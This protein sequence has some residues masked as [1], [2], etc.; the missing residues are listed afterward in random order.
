MRFST[1]PSID[2][3]PGEWDGVPE[4]AVDRV[5]AGSAGDVAFGARARLGWDADA[6]YDLGHMY[7]LN[8]DNDKAVEAFNAYLELN[9]GKDAEAQK[10]V[11]A[12]VQALGGTPATAPKKTPPKKKAPPK[13]K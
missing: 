1:P 13:K 11:E 7:K 12:E 6:W 4:V 3:D 10:N 5:I 9:K 2:A 8:H